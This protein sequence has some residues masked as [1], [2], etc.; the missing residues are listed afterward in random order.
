MFL[1]ILL[2]SSKSEMRLSKKMQIYDALKTFPFAKVAST[3]F[4][5][6]QV[7]RI[8]GDTMVVVM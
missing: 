3:S 4:H 6:E 2:S 8:K 5:E 1:D 7:D